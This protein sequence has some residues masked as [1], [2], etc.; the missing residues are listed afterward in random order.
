MKTYPKI[1][2]CV[3]AIL[4]IMT[5]IIVLVELNQAEHNKLKD[6]QAVANL[7]YF[8][9]F[10]LT[11]L[12]GE[13]F[14]QDNLKGYKVTVFNGWAPWCSMCID[15][16]PGLDALQKTYEKKG[17]QIVGVV[18]DYER[19]TDKENYQKDIRKA[20]TS[21]NISYPNFISDKNFDNSVFFMMK[22]AM[23][24]TWA[25]DE[26]GHLIEFIS[27]AADQDVWAN[28]FDC[29]LKGET[30]YENK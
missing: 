3:L 6:E 25:V 16:M 14:T 19:N 4:S 13:T 30:Y 27:G 10:T 17:L 24:G 5:C 11:S 22:H 21:T 12:D 23:P 8:E 1:L 9:N 15:E 7:H 20:V 18:A 26:N 29:W 2:K 28:I